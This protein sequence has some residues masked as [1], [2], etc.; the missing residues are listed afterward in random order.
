M[1][2]L[3]LVLV[4]LVLL[5]YVPP[6]RSGVNAYVRSLFSSCWRRKGSCRKTCRKKEEYHIFCES[7]FLCCINSKFL[8]VI[9]GK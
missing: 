7:H 4:V 9:V 3:I 6:V 2:S 8:P 1:R 5:S